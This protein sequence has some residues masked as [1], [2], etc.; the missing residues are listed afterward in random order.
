MYVYFF[1]SWIVNYA[2]LNNKYFFDNAVICDNYY[3]MLVK[4][5]RHILLDQG[6][7]KKVKFGHL[8]Q[9]NFCDEQVTFH[10]HLPNGQGYR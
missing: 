1:T 6:S 7:K 4:I 5:T 9:V 10:T 3:Y 8:G 2:T